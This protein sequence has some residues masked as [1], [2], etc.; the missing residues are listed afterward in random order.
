MFKY[1]VFIIFSFLTCTAFSNQKNLSSKKYSHALLKKSDALLKKIDEIRVPKTSFLINVEVVVFNEQK[2]SYFNLIVG[3]KDGKSFAIYTSPKVHRGQTIL[4]IK[5]NI[6][7][8]IPGTSNPFRISPQQKILG[9]ASAI[10][11]LSLQFYGNYTMSSYKDIKGSYLLKLKSKN[12]N[13]TYDSIALKVHKE[14][15]IIQKFDYFS[16]S[17]KHLKTIHASNI[18]QLAKR[19]RSSKFTIKDSLNKSLKTLIVY[20]SLHLKNI[21]KRHFS[22][23]YIKE[24]ASHYLSRNF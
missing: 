5:E 8:Y 14:S 10:D 3:A 19:K 24:L 18:R 6:W 9:Q 17:G 15:L 13:V 16:L 21:P 20:K 23:P 4:S 22:K 12:K 11:I 2:K 1:I 7:L